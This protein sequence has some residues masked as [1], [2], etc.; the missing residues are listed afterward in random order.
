MFAEYQKQ[1]LDFYK[2]KWN[3]GDLSL[4]LMHPTSAKIK[5]ECLLVF[6][7]RSK[8]KDETMLR[9]FFSADPT[10][11]FRLI[12]KK[13]ETDKF[14]PLNNYLKNSTGKT[15]EKN[16]ELLAW[17][18]DFEPRPFKPENFVDEQGN[19]E[20]SEKKDSAD[21]ELSWI[22]PEVAET[23]TTSEDPSGL[24]SGTSGDEMGQ[25][26]PTSIGPTDVAPEE[27]KKVSGNTVGRKMVLA[28][29]LLVCIGGIAAFLLWPGRQAGEV[30]PPRA[31][32]GS[33]EE[34]MYWTGDRYQAIA[35]SGK[36]DGTRLY[37]LDKDKLM[38]LQKISRPDTIS[39]RGVGHVWYAKIDGKIEF[40]TSAGFHPVYTDI[41]LKPLTLYMYNKYI[42]HYQ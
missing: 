14:K 34:C 42:Y 6:E 41:R 38:H 11:D 25:P 16:I 18:I 7:K 20:Q 4:N 17:L 35:C 5:S 33:E 30:S 12:I 9:S 32:L 19:S 2:R 1:V 28:G 37:A 3:S 40:Y 29:I 31:P 8:R 39:R 26:E 22:E 13:F 27:D 24:T 23:E 36:T 15:E 21:S 10:A